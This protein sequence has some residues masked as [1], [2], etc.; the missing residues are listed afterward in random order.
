VQRLSIRFALLGLVLGLAGCRVGSSSPVPVSEQAIVVI[1]FADSA[2]NRKV[3]EPLIAQFHELHP[4]IEVQFVS[5][6]D[7]GYS[8]LN[9]A[10][11]ADTVRLRSIP[12]GAEIVYFRDLAPFIESDR[13]FDSADFWP[14]LLPS[15]Q[16]GGVIV[17][18]PVTVSLN[19]IFFDSAAFDAAGLP[20]PAPGWTW[21]DFEKAVP[22]LTQREGDQVTR[23]GFVPWGSPTTLLGAVVGA[24]LAN[25]RDELAPT[26]LAEVLDWYVL[27]ASEG[28]IP[29]F[30]ENEKVWRQ[31]ERLIDDRQ[32]AMWV[33]TLLNL[34]RRRSSLGTEIAVSP[35]PVSA[36]GSMSSTTP[37]VPSCVA[38][39][40]GA[41]HPQEAWAWLS[42]LANH[43]ASKKPWHVPARPSVAE[44][45]GYWDNIAEETRSVHR[46][47]L[48]HAWYCHDTGTLQ[49]VDKALVQVLA[50]E[51][52]LATALALAS[53]GSPVEPVATSSR[54]PVVI[55]TPRPT[56]MS[57]A[58]VTVDY[59][60]NTFAHTTP[61]AIEALAQEFN[62]THSGIKVNTS[63]DLVVAGHG[64]FTLFDVAAQ[65]DCFAWPGN[66][67]ALDQLYSLDPLLETLDPQ[68]ADDFH[69]ALLDAFRIDGELYAL[70]GSTLPTVIYYNADHLAKMGLESPTLDWT[71]DDFFALAAA[72]M[73]KEGK[74]KTYGFVPFQGDAVGFLLAVQDVRLYNLNTEPPVV[75]LDHPD[76]VNAVTWMVSQVTDGIMPPYD[77]GGTH[78]LMGNHRQREK[79]VVSGHAALWTD[80]A[81]LR[82]GFRADEAPGFQVGTAPLPLVPGPLLATPFTN[83]LYISRRAIDPAACWQWLTFLSGQP[84]AFRGV[85]AR[86]SV[87]ESEA[88]E[89]TV[90]TDMA[91]AYRTA[92]SLLAL[93][94]PTHAAGKYPLAPIDAW[95]QD[96]LTAAFGG[97]DVTAVLAEAQRKADDY[98]ACLTL[99]SDSIEEQSILCAK[100]ADPEFK[101]FKELLK[102]QSP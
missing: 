32:A 66:P 61:L 29:I 36:D 59:Y 48:E 42:F 53:T 100:A 14:G 28:S 70:P 47:A 18:L 44:T 49:A 84:N 34:S 16:E 43:P 72:A 89:S 93:A 99:S 46:F 91:R 5:L 3:Y 58:V 4:T 22:A 90:D 33:D 15:L 51:T 77:D 41:N 52:D 80:L 67:I 76:V 25:T 74:S 2:S 55:A 69:P 83:S 98:L 86:R 50:G 88:W 26:A 40:A 35:F 95:W 79:L 96:A 78:S 38:M 30:E 97:K 64:G 23:Y 27:L 20:R 101:T 7:E 37:A 57:E 54:T 24:V 1:T 65:F 85:P 73:S 19:L 45:S 75:Y 11:A 71:A 13:T 87:I 17:A 82:G 10:S 102:E 6:D 62:S 8:P 21:D 9:V 94:H 39:S 63:T 60:I 12:R 31:N 68:L 92:L 56:A 81:S